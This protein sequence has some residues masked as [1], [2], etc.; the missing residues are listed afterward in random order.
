VFIHGGLADRSFWAPQMDALGDRF[1]LVALDLGGHGVAGR[2]RERWTVAAW[3]EDVRAVVEATGGRRVVLIGNSLG[4]PVALEAAAR[5]P[6]R[7]LGVVAVDTLQDMTEKIPESWTQARAKAFR[8]DFPAACRAMVDML[9]HTGEQLELHAWAEQRMCAA[10]AEVVAQMIENWA[11][12]DQVAVGKAAGIPI[13]AIN[14]DLFPTSV[15]KNRAA[16]LDFDAVIM[17]GTGHYPQLERPAEFNARLVEIVASLEAGTA[18][19]RRP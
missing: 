16:G 6:G 2:D 18:Q 4:G 14:G 5:L 1:A 11:G 13:R 7:V 10:P 8:E 15:E 19:G 3:G 9:F 17:P 12:Y